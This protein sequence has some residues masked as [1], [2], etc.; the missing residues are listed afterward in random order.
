MILGSWQR[1]KFPLTQAVAIL[2]ELKPFTGRGRYVFSSARS[3]QRPMSDN[4]VTGNQAACLRTSPYSD[5]KSAIG[6]GLSVRS[7]TDS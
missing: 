5:G 6:V 7:G 3:G 1:R 2:R 4:A